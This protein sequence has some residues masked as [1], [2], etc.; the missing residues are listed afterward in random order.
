MASNKIVKNSFTE[1]KCMFSNA[2]N[3]VE[4][5]D[6]SSK[7]TAEEV[8]PL[9]P[10]VVRNVALLLFHQLTPVLSGCFLHCE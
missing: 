9:Y 5:S 8:L 6:R 4:K 3:E 2:L 10:E 7:L 1:F